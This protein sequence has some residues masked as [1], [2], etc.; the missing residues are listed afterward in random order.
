MLWA[1]YDY[2]LE[3]KSRFLDRTEEFL[4]SG[5]EITTV[6]IK[7]APVILSSLRRGGITEATSLRNTI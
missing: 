3:E 4:N 7:A 5:S 1:D 2:N 6:M